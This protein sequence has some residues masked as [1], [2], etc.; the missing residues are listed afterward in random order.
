[1]LT[2]KRYFHRLHCGGRPCSPGPVSIRLTIPENSLFHGRFS[3]VTPLQTLLT[4][5]HG[6]SRMRC[7]VSCGHPCN[8]WLICFRCGGAALGHPWFR[9]LR[10][11]LTEPPAIRLL[12]MCSA[13][14]PGPSGH[15]SQEGIQAN[16]SSQES[17]LERGAAKRR[18]VRSAPIADTPYEHTLGA[19]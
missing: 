9:L 19:P 15:P 1:M 13:T 18:G 11:R 3:S 16:L 12:N 2:G 8:P 14:H 4:T 7:L 5:D 6:F 17:P 10:F